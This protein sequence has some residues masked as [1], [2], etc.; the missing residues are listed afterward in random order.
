MIVWGKAPFLFN[1]MTSCQAPDFQLDWA[2]FKH[3]VFSEHPIFWSNVYGGRKVKGNSSMPKTIHI[4]IHITKWWTVSLTQVRHLKLWRNVTLEVESLHLKAKQ[5]GGAS[6][7]IESNA[8]SAVFACFWQK[9]FQKESI[10]PY[11]PTGLLPT[12]LSTAI[13][14]P[15]KKRIWRNTKNIRYPRTFQFHHSSSIND[16]QWQKYSTMCP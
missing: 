5:P 14:K 9:H 7:T 3:K 6:T 4:T 10:N 16:L 15:Q 8:I 13:E 11:H 2:V 12:F 1:V